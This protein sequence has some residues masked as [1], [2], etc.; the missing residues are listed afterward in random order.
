VQKTAWES[1]PYGCLGGTKAHR[2]N[3]IAYNTGKHKISTHQAVYESN[4]NAGKAIKVPL[5]QL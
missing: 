4:E 3:I 1:T 2:E 5:F